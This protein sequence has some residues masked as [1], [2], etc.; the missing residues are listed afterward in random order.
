MPPP[1]A[2]YTTWTERVRET[3]DRYAEPLSRAVSARLVQPKIGQTVE[4]LADKAAATQTNAPVIDRRI[5]EL[6]E[7]PQTLLR[8]VGLSRQPIWNVGQLIT[9]SAAAG[10][11]DGFAPLQS[12][13]EAGLIFPTQTP[14]NA[15]ITDFTAWFG[16]AGMLAASVF[17]HP[18]VAA[19]SREIGTGEDRK[20][21]RAAPTPTAGGDGLDWPLR[22]AA[23]WQRTRQL[24]VKMTQAKLLFKRDLTRLQA[25]DLLAAP[26]I[27]VPEKV[28]DPGV[29]A[30]EWAA[31]AGMFRPIEMEY[32]A[33]A[34]LGSWPAGLWALLTHLF[35]AFFQVETWDP[36]KGYAP[37]DTALS[38]TATAALILFDQMALTPGKGKTAADLAAPLWD[39]H[40]SF[41]SA[42]SREAAKTQGAGW[43]EALLLTV[44][45]PLRVVEVQ[46]G[47]PRTFR[48]SDFGRYL[49]C[50]EP[51]PQPPAAFPQ[52]LMVQPNAEVLVYRQG[53]T[54][55]LIAELS[56]FAAWKQIGP[57]CTLELNAE[58]TYHGLESGLTLA[59]IKQ[60]LDRHA[61]RPVPNNVADLLRRW[62]DKRERITVYP[63]A[64]LVE[65]TT[66]ADLDLALSRGLVAIKLTDL[67]GLTADGREPEFKALRLIGNRE[68]DAKPVKCL[69]IA[70][71]GLTIAVDP[72]QADLL[73]EAEIAR[74][75][76]PLP[77]TGNGPRQF[78]LTPRT[79]R[80]A[81]E[82]GQSL[83]ELDRWFV[84]RTGNPLTP[85]GRLFVTGPT[86]S[87]PVTE[88]CRI[89]RLSS[90]EIADGI[91][92]WPETCGLILDRLGPTVVMIEEEN[93]TRL[94]EVLAEIGVQLKDS[95]PT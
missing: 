23:V 41:P 10:H 81:T 45:V 36:L 92:Q 40:P 1:I 62:A 9:L 37:S 77:V 48:L 18:A 14:G 38:P 13:L 12:L 61:M 51:E 7:G 3:L 19:R 17:V 29:L 66:P 80:Q 33:D 68:Y 78:R 90:V 50:G 44:A 85:A 24:P 63:T 94:R 67:I 84:S 25:D 6:P 39:R 74:L 95:Q 59:G 49:F 35:A 91:V 8:L 34:V 26:L 89:V 32:H 16:G 22:L 31:A 54:P 2:D 15:P 60:T 88:T 43:V 70:D 76:E 42:L 79:L 55:P 69:T 58:E 86:V 83:D 20:K 53:L 47:E 11:A 65:F 52:T 56:R 82:Q 21:A 93:L 72:V 57:A 27:D 71:D 4:D 28:A 46:A 5:R 75:A 87:S 64:T 30:F 73:L